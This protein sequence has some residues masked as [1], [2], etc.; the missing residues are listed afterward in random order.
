MFFYF[1]L[2]YS[3]VSLRSMIREFI[4]QRY[5]ARYDSD[6][7]GESVGRYSGY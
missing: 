4:V 7:N 3:P 2:T 1:S 5:V 6:M